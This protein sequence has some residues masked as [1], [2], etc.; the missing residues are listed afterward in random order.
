MVRVKLKGVASA[1]SKGK[2][3][4]YAWRGG[5]RLAGLPESPEFIASYHEAHQG[6]F[7][8][9]SSRIS[10]LVALYRASPAYTGLRDSTKRE[11]SRWLDRIVAHFG[12]LHVANFDRTQKIRPL[13]AAWRNKWA[14]KPRSADY[15]VQVLSRLLSFACEPEVALLSRNPCTGLKQLYEVDRSE[16]IWSAADLD[17]FALVAPAQVN[18]VVVLAAH[19]GLRLGDLLRLSWSNVGDRLVTIRTSKSNYKREAIIPLYASLRATLSGIPRQA[20]TILTN[21]RGIPWTP[22]GFDSSFRA[23][24]EAAGLKEAGLHFHDLRGT[25]ATKFYQAGV[26]VRVIAE[27]IRWEEQS[28]AKI[29]RRYVGANAATLE[30]IRLI[31]ESERRTENAKPTAKP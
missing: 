10:G 21:T 20:A 7:A 14:D 11:W 8:V 24:L 4:Y 26:D 25:A 3:Y 13:I 18:N 29:I 15:A 23:A 30:A 22:N 2:R 19:T 28:V 17:A 6:R 5:P 9:D 31:E 1:K 12:E 27:I 16:K